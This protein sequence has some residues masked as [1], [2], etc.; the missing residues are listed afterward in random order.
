MEKGEDMYRGR[1]ESSGYIDCN[2]V[3]FNI[4]NLGNDWIIVIWL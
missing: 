4:S 2:F 1:V 3:I